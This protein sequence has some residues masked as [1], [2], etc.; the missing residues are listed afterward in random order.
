ML[1]LVEKTP[2]IP[3]VPGRETSAGP[4]RETSVNKCCTGSDT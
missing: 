1:D 3:A 2:L 4:G